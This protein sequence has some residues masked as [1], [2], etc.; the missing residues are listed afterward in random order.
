MKRLQEGPRAPHLNCA[1]SKKHMSGNGRNSIYLAQ[2]G[3]EF[4]DLS[5]RDVCLLIAFSMAPHLIGTLVYALL[6][7]SLE[8][9]L[10]LMTWGWIRSAVILV[11][12][13][14]ISVAGLGIREGA[15]LYLLSSYGVPE[16][17][18]MAMAFLVFGTVLLFLTMGGLLEGRKVFMSRTPA[19]SED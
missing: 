7:A 12:L 17:Q 18:A 15:M 13:L 4:K 8:I 10:D 19:H 9:H 3:L 14:P 11:T 6:A 1:R 5:S 16:E 2:L